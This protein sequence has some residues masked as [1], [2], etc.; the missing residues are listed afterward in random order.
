MSRTDDGSSRAAAPL[1]WAVWGLPVRVK[2]PVLAVDAAGVATVLFGTGPQR[3]DQVR[4]SAPTATTT[5]T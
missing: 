2:V 3:D 5:L 4:L 1:G